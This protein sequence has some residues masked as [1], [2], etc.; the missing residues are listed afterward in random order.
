MGHIEVLFTRLLYKGFIVVPTIQN[1]ENAFKKLWYEGV[2]SS[3]FIV[4]RSL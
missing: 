3:I 1:S 4:S 2:S